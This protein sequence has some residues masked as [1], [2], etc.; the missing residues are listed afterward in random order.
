MSDRVTTE[1]TGGGDPRRSIELLW[2]LQERKRRGP[3]PRLQVPDIVRAAIAIADGEG[4]GALSM[5]RVADALGVA[6]MSLYS[7]VPGKA[8]LLDLMLDTV[9]GETPRP[10][11]SD[12][13][14]GLADIARSNWDLYHRHPWM[15]QIVAYRPP[16][17]PNL[18]AKYEYELSAVDGIGLTDLEMDHVLTLVGSYAAAAARGS[19]E[20]AMAERETGISDADWWAANAPLL[21]QVFDATRFPIASRVGS[22]AGE[23][24]AAPY[25][26]DSAFAF[27]LERVLDGIEVLIRRV[28]AT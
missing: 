16:L 3:K 22:A 13:R 18:I 17:G 24:Y 14:S 27:G 11:I 19:V 25:S 10:P 4:L 9:S 15:L 26:P 20:A 12:W 23:E 21:E 5:R 7:Y 6:T 8:E 28:R 2:G 1:F